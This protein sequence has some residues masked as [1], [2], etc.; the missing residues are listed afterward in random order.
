MLP[1]CPQY[2]FSAFAVLRLGAIVVNINPS[3]TAREVLT[4]AS[5]SGLRAADHAR[6]ARAAGAGRARTDG[7]RADHRHVARRNIRPPARRAAASST[8]TRTMAD[9][10]GRVAAADLPA[11]P[12]RP[13]RRRRAA[14]HR[15]HH[16]HAEGR[17]A[18]PREHLG[19]RRAD[20]EL[21]QPGLHRQRP[22]TLSRGHPLLPHLRV[23]GLHDGR[24]ADRR[25]ADHP[26][27]VRA[28]GG[29]GVDPGFP[30][31]LLSRGAD[32]VRLA[33][34][35]PDASPSTGSSTSACSTAAARPVRS[36]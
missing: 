2:I 18:D 6:R 1:N 29:A 36:R 22:R 21:D 25:A 31:D 5:D 33:A 12:D 28:R 35:P 11:V 7:D 16:R 34:Q 4:V 15:R 20:R 30:A 26:P 3:Y 10:L 14:V 27:E 13:G 17:D 23:L 8:R 9:L 19:Q 32:G 24:A